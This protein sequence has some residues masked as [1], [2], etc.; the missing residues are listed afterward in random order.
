MSN[1]HPRSRSEIT[2]AQI[3]AAYLD[4]CEDD[5]FD[6]V[7]TAA[8]LVARADDRIE[9][10]EMGRLADFLD[11]H[12]FP[13]VFTRAEVSDAFERRIR[14]LAELGGSEA[15]MDD[16][17]R[18][19][20]RSPARLVIAAGEEVAAADGHIDS[21]EQHILQRIRVALAERSR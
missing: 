11:R 2:P 17:A 1:R 16:L 7:V 8:A 6:A 21:R 12:R 10:T 18:Q 5:L 9:P 4:G 3:M 20:G 15:V 13:S 14:E 19:A